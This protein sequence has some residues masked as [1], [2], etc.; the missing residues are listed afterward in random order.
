MGDTALRIIPLGGLGEIGKNMMAYEYGDDILIV[1]T[2]LMFPPNDLPGIDYIIPDFQYLYDKAHRVRGIVY[3]H[4]H[5]DHTGAVRHVLERIPAPMYAT[6]L[7]KGL[8]E[9][10]LKGDKV[11]RN[12]PIHEVKA[13]QRVRIGAFTVEFIHVTHSIPD[14]VALAISSPEGVVIHTGDYKFDQTPIDGKPTDFAA[15][16]SYARRGKGVLALLADSTNADKPGWTPSER[17]ITPALEAAMREAPGRVLVAT[18]ASLI[19]RMQQVA[20]VALRLGRKI[21]FVGTSM[22]ENA[23]MARK[24]GYLRIPDEAWIT[25]EEALNLPPQEVVLMVTGSQ[26]EPSSILGRLAGLGGRGRR[27]FNIEAGDTVIIAAHPIPGN[28]ENVYRT[29]NRLIQR[30]AQVLYDPVAQVHVSGHASQEEMKLM[31]NLVQP[32]YFI[33]IHGEL[34]HLVQHARLAQQV[35]IPKDRIAVVENGQV[36]E[37]RNGQMRL[38]ERV[39]GSWVFVEGG[40][41]SET[42]IRDIWDR[43]DLARRG[44][45][46]VEVPVSAATGRL[47]GPIEVITRGFSLPDGGEEFIGLLRKRIKRTLAK[48]SSGDVEK[49]L[50]SITQNLAYNE[51]RRRPIVLVFLKP[52]SPIEAGNCEQGA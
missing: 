24:L 40:V 11:L 38:A 50:T 44:L 30:G 3:T 25:L 33:P 37:F 49:T 8:L 48:G 21:A 10:K 18:F 20:E 19:S 31:L 4:G 6:P 1:D 35:G 23:R 47:A 26:G 42:S 27:P 14:A 7:T 34:R 13:G 45:L 2:G 46:L 17:V 43:Q 51:L 28:A 39:P 32:R 52:Q 36:I 16:A 15:L 12:I 41:V 5:E 29:I 22:V 9:V